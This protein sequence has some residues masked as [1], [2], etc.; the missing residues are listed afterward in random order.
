[1]TRLALI[2]SLAALL[3][4]APPSEAFQAQNPGRVALPV[5]VTTDP[6]I[7]LSRAA[8]ALRAGGRLLAQ[9]VVIAG[10]GRI[11]T[12]LSALGGARQVDVRYPNGRTI[13]ALLV[14]QDDEQNLALLQPRTGS[15]PNGVPLG[16]GARRATRATVSLGDPPGI[17][18]LTFA[19]R[20]TFVEGSVL[21]RDAWQLDPVPVASALGSGALNERGELAA[22]LVASRGGSSGPAA[23]PSAYGAPV[24]AVSAL[25]ARAGDTARPWLGFTARASRGNEGVVQ[26]GTRVPSLRILE[27][28]AGGPAERAGLVGGPRPDE[29][30]QADGV[31]VGTEADLG[32][33]LDRHRPG[34]TI[35]LRVAR[36]GSQY[37][38]SLTLGRFPAL[39][40]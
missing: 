19:R 1:M 39:V 38:L 37:E 23:P 40:P 34:D 26:A 5:I 18:S 7:A 4:L 13:S 24:S 25:L 21:L 11:V 8:V 16:A 22:V 32:R 10:D 17:S 9:G 15:W 12:C 33:V 2:P 27:V 3:A 20:R 14:A 36:G 31:P 30:L 29:L 35:V 28:A 6:T